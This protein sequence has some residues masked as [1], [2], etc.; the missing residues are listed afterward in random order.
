[1]L[2]L[3]CFAPCPAPE[4]RAQ[5][6]PIQELI[7]SARRGPAT[8]ELK[9]RITTVLSARG[10]TAVWGQDFLFVTDSPSPATISI[11][12]QPAVAMSPIEGS[13]LW[14]YLKKMRTG[15]THSYQYYAGGKPLGNRGDAIGY[16]PD[17]YQKPGYLAAT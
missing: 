16:N 5:Q 15:V 8:P 13:T 17:S 2:L 1:M 9:D 12:Q 10:G 11:D 4:L 3:A 14:I 6:A 7:E